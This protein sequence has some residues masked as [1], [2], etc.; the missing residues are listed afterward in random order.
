MGLT[1]SWKVS[2]NTF[3]FAFDRIGDKQT[4]IKSAI[5]APEQNDS[6]A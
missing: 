1:S 6:Y 3:I 2:A 4:A 5:R